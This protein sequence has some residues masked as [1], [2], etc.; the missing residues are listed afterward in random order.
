VHHHCQ[1]VTTF[2]MSQNLYNVAIAIK[3]KF[4]ILKYIYYKQEA[5]HGGSCLSSLIPG[6]WR[7]MTL[8]DFKAVYIVISRAGLHSKTLSQIN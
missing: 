1:A 5:R 3:L 7:E 4:Y 6:W 8:C 2:I